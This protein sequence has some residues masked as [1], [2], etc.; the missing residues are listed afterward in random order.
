MR[1]LKKTG[2]PPLVHGKHAHRIETQEEK[3]HQVF[4]GKTFGNKMRMKKAQAAQ[5]ARARA[6]MGK[7]GDKNGGRIPDNDHAYPALPVQRKAYLPRKQA[8][9]RRKFTRLLGAV[10]P[11][12]R[13]AALSQPVE[14]FQLAWLEACGIAF[15]AGGYCTP[16]AIQ[17][18]I[19]SS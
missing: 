8:G 16:P 14:S 6:D 10:A 11:L 18:A 5:T 4:M 17:V 9:E 1:A 15:D 19:M 12:R 3:V 2:L 13:V 7:F